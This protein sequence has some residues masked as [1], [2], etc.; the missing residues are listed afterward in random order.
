MVSLTFDGLSSNFSAC[1]H[2][3]ANFQMEK[4]S[5]HIYNPVDKSKIY[6]MPDACH[7]IKLVRN[8]MASEQ[9][10]HNGA[11][12]KIEWQYIE[13]LVR[14]RETKGFTT[15]KLTKR[16]I[17]WE[18]SVMDMRIAA[19][20][21]SNSVAEFLDC[22]ATADFVRRMNDLFDTLNTKRKGSDRFFRNPI[23]KENRIEIFDF[24]DE[25]KQYIENLT[26]GGVKV[27]QTRK[28][29]GFKGLLICMMSIKNINNDYIHNDHFD[30]IPTFNLSQDP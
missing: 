18:R 28:R 14:R 6:L 30:R 21:L 13:K 5:P 3:G 7:M 15:H 22:E 27:L 19:Q 26:I 4:L 24:F 9:V 10:F 23:T 2:L 17:Q 25:V 1:K 11:G 29:T 8:F 16:H 12:A 20:T